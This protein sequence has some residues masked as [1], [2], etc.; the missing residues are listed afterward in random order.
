MNA[1]VNVT[2]CK[3][4]GYQIEEFN[5]CPKCGAKKITKRI[6]FRNLVDDFADRYLNLDNSLLKTFVDLFK[7]PSAVI[8]GYIHGVRKRYINAFSYFAIAITITGAYSFLVKDKL[9]IMITQA[10]DSAAQMEIQEKTFDIVSQYN[11]IISFM[12]IPLLAIL[13][14]IVFWNYKKYNLTEHFV[15]YLYAYSHIIA[16]V[17]IITLPFVF[18]V[19]QFWEVTA[20]QFLIYILYVAYVLKELY[21][22]NLKSIILKTLLFLVLGGIGYFLVSVGVVILLM[23]IGVI[24]FAEMVNMQAR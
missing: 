22:L 8:D 10:S 11:S 4:C 3:N 18:T 20:L 12:F 9:K 6:T 7:R 1:L 15:I 21:Q 5:F 2:N 16:V 24:D 14:R 17:S 19:D 23:A 13:S